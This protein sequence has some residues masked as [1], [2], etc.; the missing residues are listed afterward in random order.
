MDIVQVNV[1]NTTTNQT[2]PMY[3]LVPRQ[4]DDSAFT[5]F[6]VALSVFVLLVLAYFFRSQ[7][8][9]CARTILV[10]YRDYAGHRPVPLNS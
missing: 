10:K 6:M 9:S 8:R 4:E 1:T 2:V 7:L 5:G 3:Y